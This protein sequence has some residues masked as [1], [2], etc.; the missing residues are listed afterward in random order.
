[1]WSICWRNFFR[2]SMRDFIKGRRKVGR[3]RIFL[4]PLGLGTIVLARKFHFNK[5]EVLS[6]LRCTGTHLLHLQRPSGR[7]L[8]KS[9][10]SRGRRYTRKHGSAKKTSMKRM[11]S[12]GTGSPS[13]AAEL[14]ILRG[15]GVGK[16]SSKFSRLRLRKEKRKKPQRLNRSSLSRRKKE[17]EKQQRR[18]SNI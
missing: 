15:E 16:W 12:V 13:Q 6:N 14:G 2:K 7:F 17:T 18:R 5:R 10:S 1:V 11:R 8:S 4:S 9:F 3:R